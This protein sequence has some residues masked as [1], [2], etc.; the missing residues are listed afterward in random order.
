MKRNMLAKKLT[1]VFLTGVM[2]LSMGGMNA[3]AAGDGINSIELKKTVTTDGD[4]FAPA[5]TFTFNVSPANGGTMNGNTVYRGID[6]GLTPSA[7]NNFTFAPEGEN[8]EASYEKLGAIDVNSELFTTPG[9]YH[10]TVNEVIPE[11][12]YEG[13]DYDE[14]TYDLYVY[15]IDDNGKIEVAG[16][17]TEVAGAD[18]E[19]GFG[20]ATNIEF[21]NDYGKEEENNS[22]HD[23]KIIKE[24]SG[25]QGDK[26]KDFTFWLDVKGDAGEWYK[27]V[28]TSQEGTQSV[29]HLVSEA[30]PVSYTLRDGESIQI[31]GLS[32]SDTYTVTED[33]Y[34]SDGYKTTIDDAE[35]RTKTDTVSADG[36]VITVENTKNVTTPTGIA[37]TFA[38]YAVMVVFAG[39]FAV[40]FL[41]KKREDF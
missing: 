20:K 32:A 23:V 19:E 31:F 11:E 7:D 16:V 14:K 39:V 28:K 12:K 9:I 33:D 24:V 38:P 13:I 25:N 18:E 35:I 6:N 26:T 40:M 17:A 10:Y 22:T 37:M 36:T 2:A 29:S 27:V 30:E 8:P 4:T 34:S 3:F 41:R 21:I 5:T 15:V 1:A